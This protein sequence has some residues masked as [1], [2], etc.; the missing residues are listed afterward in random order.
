[1][2]RPR[3][4]TK[5]VE[6][7]MKVAAV[8][9]AQG[10]TWREVAEALGYA[11][12]RVAE[13]RC[14]RGADRELWRRLLKAAIQEWT[15]QMLEPLALDTLRKLMERVDSKNEMDRKLAE[16][17]AHSV[18]GHAAKLRGMTIKLTGT[19]TREEVDAELIEDARRL[20]NRAAEGK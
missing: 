11:N 6:S 3:G 12:E 14:Q 8:M 18:L 5:R 1:M 9:R 7:K 19:V 17:A 20:A 13:K 15:E 10:R 4:I 2:G 16:A